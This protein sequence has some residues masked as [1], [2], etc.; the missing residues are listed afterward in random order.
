[1]IE[2]IEEIGS[3]THA[4]IFEQSLG[5]SSDLGHHRQPLQCPVC[6]KWYSTKGTLKTHQKTHTG[7]R[8]FECSQCHRNSLKYLPIV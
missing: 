5:L 8:P 7:E 1:M 6:D 4:E 2:D 3:E